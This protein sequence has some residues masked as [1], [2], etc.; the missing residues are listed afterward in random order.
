MVMTMHLTVLVR[1]KWKIL[2]VTVQIVYGHAQT[3]SEARPWRHPIY[4]PCW[5]QKHGPRQFVK[6]HKCTAESLR[7]NN[8]SHFSHTGRRLL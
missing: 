5:R 7:K 2:F 3:I 1:E 8:L 4:A 6:V